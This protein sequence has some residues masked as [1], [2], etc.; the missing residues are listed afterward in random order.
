MTGFWVCEACKS[1][2]RDTSPACYQCRTPRP[3]VVRE[4]AVGARGAVLT[5]GMD[6]ELQEVAFLLSEGHRVLPVRWLARALTGLVLG[7]IV[8]TLVGAGIA[9]Y[10]GYAAVAIHPRPIVSPGLVSLVSALDIGLIATFLLALLAW[11]AFEGM[12]LHNAPLLGAGTPSMPIWAALLWWFVPILNIVVPIRAVVDLHARLAS[13]GSGG[14][15]A[16]GVW[17]A[18]YLVSS[19]LGPILIV[20]ITVAGVGFS[21]ASFAGVPVQMTPTASGVVTGTTGIE[22]IGQLLRV[23]AGFAFIKVVTDI[24]S[25]QERRIAWLA[26]GRARFGGSVPG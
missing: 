22:L 1:L 8:L 14:Q 7:N 18:C 21:L 2:V 6:S 16:V 15:L 3:A 20:I 9:V 12:S 11:L 10:L 13:K 25:R 23:V 4:L 26:E 24:E 19:F 17:W 5:P